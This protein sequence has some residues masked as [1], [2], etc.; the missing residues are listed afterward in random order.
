MAEGGWL[1]GEASCAEGVRRIG[2]GLHDLCQ[3]LT[4]LQC[5]L[6]LATLVGTA[7]A[8]RE[9]VERAL[10]ECDRLTEAVGAM[11]AIVRAAT[12]DGV[13]ERGGSCGRE[14]GDGE[15]SSSAG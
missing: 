9:A 5:R 14:A 15:R 11:R 10:V 7:E 12:A 8:Y 3:P 1:C 2:K 6:E 13:A 4:T